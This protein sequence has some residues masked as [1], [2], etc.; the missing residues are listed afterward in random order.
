MSFVTTW[1]KL[2]VI[3]LSETSQIKKDK[4]HMES[5]TYGIFKKK[6]VEFTEIVESG[7]QELGEWETGS[8]VK[9]YKLSVLK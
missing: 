9:R 5:L 1:V 8:L 4:Y 7:C 3:M 2:E 6:K